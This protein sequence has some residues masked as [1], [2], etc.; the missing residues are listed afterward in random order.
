M[1][2]K[3]L[4]RIELYNLV[5]TKPVTHIAKEYG[6]SDTAIRKICIKHKIPLPK[7]GYWSKLKFNKKVQKTKLP[8][9]DENPRIS[10]IKKSYTPST[11]L[12]FIKEKIQ[13]SFG[14]KLEV[15]KKLNK[16]H[17]FIT[18][19][20]VY[21]NK[22]KVR[23]KKNDWS[24]KIDTLDVINIDVSD[25]LFARA[26]KF[27]NTLI[28]LLE[29][30]NYQITA[31][32]ETKIT[33]REQHYTIRLIEKHKRVKKETTYNWDSF[34]L[35]TTGNLCLKLEHSYPI[36]EWTDSK[37]KPIEEKLIDIISWLELKVKNDEQQAI[38]RAIRHKQQEEKCK[39]AEELQRLKDEE[40]SKFESLF[41]TATR[42]HKSQYI[43]NYIQEFENFTI[44][45]NNL[46][47]KEKEW[48]D[49]A[50]EKADWYDPF[51]EKEIVL[52]ED[53]NRDTLKEKS[54]YKY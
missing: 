46:N 27:M 38:A 29:K 42:W 21:H 23:N 31:D 13:N 10:L 20:K 18:A 19:T 41:L 28:F 8:K 33:I 32:L 2:N 43:R 35:E 9:Q 37:T 14:N 16:P 53:I 12:T 11:E 45:S 47:T 40:L 44:K 52:L 17:K 24:M 48:I 1:E 22:L 15:P 51:I 36:K 54:R 30:N 7:L 5:W 3:S 4:T 26:L 49:W 25:K 34:D 6:F 39:K 50:K